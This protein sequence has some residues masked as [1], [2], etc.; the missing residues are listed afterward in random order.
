L[1]T[2][3]KSLG[4]Y[5]LTFFYPSVITT[6]QDWV[7][8]EATWVEFWLPLLVFGGIF[9]IAG[10]Y[11]LRKKDPVLL[12]FSAWV[13]LGLGLHMNLVPLDATVADRWFYFPMVGLLGVLAVLFMRLRGGWAGNVLSLVLPVVLLAALSVRSFVR[14]QDWVDGFTL[15]SHDLQ[16]QPDSYYLTNNY[17][18]ELFR[19]GRVQEAKEYFEKSTQLAPHWFT[20]W[21]NL[22]A[23]Y[24]ALGD[25]DRAEQCYLRSLNTSLYY[26]AYENYAK[27]LLVRGKHREAR[28][29][30]MNTALPAFPDNPWLKAMLQASPQ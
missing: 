4:H 13:L 17:G 30:I 14:S 7:V 28:D 9:V 18:V 10:R 21:N 11:F 26:L 29:F 12:F 27:I 2:I 23:T 24:E 16:F 25:L 6:A 15:Y 3:P 19:K 20:N 8:R 1:L 22:G 5:F